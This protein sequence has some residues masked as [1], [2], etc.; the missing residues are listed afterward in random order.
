[1]ESFVE[2][3]SLKFVLEILAGKMASPAGSGVMATLK[4]KMQGL[5]DEMEKYRDM[6]EDKCKETEEE[7]AKRSSV[8]TQL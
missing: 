1:L 8:S 4:Q 6:Y 7:R 5:R 2:F 3:R